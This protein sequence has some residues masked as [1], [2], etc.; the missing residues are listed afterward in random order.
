LRARRAWIGSERTHA[1][2][3]FALNGTGTSALVVADAKGNV[4][5]LTTTVNAPFGSGVFAPRSGVLLNDE[6][7]DFTDPETTARFGAAPGPNAPR[8][9]AR[10]A[11]SMTPTIVLR[12]GAPEVVA[13]GSGGSRIPVNLVQVLL[14]R[15]VFAKTLEA[16]VAAPRFFVPANGPT[17][18][19]NAEQVP[20]LAVQ[21]DLLERG[22]QLKL[23]TYPDVTAIQIVTL[24]RAGGGEPRLLAA[25]DPRKG[26]VALVR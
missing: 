18:S 3:R 5:A 15:L 22:E 24:D 11:S 10:P 26:G 19:Y 20:P 1:P 2:Q 21:L 16:C 8:G 25:A 4:V 23:I 13:A 12:D 6:L 17:L 9:G 7:T 14:C